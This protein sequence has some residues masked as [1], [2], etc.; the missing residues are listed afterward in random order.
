[1]ET[2]ANYVLIGAFTLAVI[3]GAFLFV[4]W[5]SGASKTAEH[6]TYRIVFTGSV[7]G[8]SR[9]SAVLFN[10][11]NVGSVRSIDFLEKDPSRVA[12]LVDVAGRTPIKTDTKARLELQGLTGVAAIALTGG[13]E[14]T[15]SLE[16]GADGAPPTINAEPSQLQ[17]LLE[18]VQRLSVRADDLIGK[19]NKLI[20]ENGPAITD[21][22]AN[23]DTFSKALADNSSGVNAALKGVADLGRTI[24]PLTNKLQSLSDDVDSLVKAVNVDQVR[25][26]IDKAHDVA[27]NVDAFSAT[28]ARNSASVDSLLA[29][30]AALAKKLNQTAGQLDGALADFRG[31]A[32]AIDTKKIGEVI[33]GVDN[34]VS[35]VEAEKVRGA[36]NNLEA[37]S[38]TLANNKDHVDS[39]LA[40]AA[41]LAKKLTG[42]A[43]Q[44]DG[45]LGDVRNLAK[46]IDNTKVAN[47]VDRV[48]GIVGAVDP[49]KVRGA[50][51]NVQAF[52]ATLANNKDHVDSLL[53]DAATLAKKLPATADQLDGA[54]G[55][56]RDLAKAVDQK[57]IAGIVDD[58]S[59]FAEALGENQ[60]NVDRALKNASE[61]AA[62]LNNS[63][64]RLDELMV[65][66]QNFLGSPE[67][68]GAVAEV[69]DAA[70]SVRQFADDLNQRTK[71]IAVGLTRFSGSGLR[72]YEAL[73]I[74]A[75]RTIGDLDHAI[76]SFERSPNQLIF[77]SKPALPEFH[78]GQ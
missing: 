26:I 53:A 49:D 36:I 66:A 56:F 30:T 17:N 19:A 44:L 50:V 48:D 25:G 18:T 12:A 8:L 41:T 57:K 22:L 35:A 78:G 33:D 31:L 42:T 39:L 73:A 34:L 45:A 52:S 6:K 64:D 74:D 47:V 7:S 20:D 38:A 40:D 9:G 70:R 32:K 28:L 71:D 68:K 65:S 75:R 15:P 76:R 72:E 59:K 55:D 37:F 29:D 24:A 61:L 10:G 16:P 62:K 2:K 23:A 11:L 43:D 51:D 1:M 13:A 14:S 63:A 54:L 5:L 67:T 4:L 3:V 77:G 69:G 60:G 21:T 27:N 46:A 58:A